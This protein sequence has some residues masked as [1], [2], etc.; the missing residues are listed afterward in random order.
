MLKYQFLQFFNIG[1]STAQ[2]FWPVS[3]G[4][5]GG[6]AHG[7]GG[8]GI[9]GKMRLCFR[10][11]VLLQLSIPQPLHQKLTQMQVGDTVVV[12]TGDERSH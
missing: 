9:F 7:F 2:F 8:C 12:V 4:L 3:S 5:I 6:H 1:Q 10:N 11:C